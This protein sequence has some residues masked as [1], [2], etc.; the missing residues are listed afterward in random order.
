MERLTT[1]D[2]AGILDLVHA[3][4]DVD[5]SDEFPDV[6]LQGVM[7]IVPCAVATMN[8]VEPSADRFVAWTR[9]AS[10]ATTALN[11]PVVGVSSS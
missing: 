1:G 2:L 9:P 11:R 10:F 3:L 4:G 8:E 7:N 6:S 5:D